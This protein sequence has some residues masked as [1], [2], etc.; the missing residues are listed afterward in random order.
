MK[1]LKHFNEELDPQ[2]YISAGR[3]LKNYGKNTKGNKLVDYGYEKSH[4]FYNTHIQWA[5]QNP[6]YTGKITNPT[7]NFYYGLPKWNGPQSNVNSQLVNAN[8]TEDELVRDWKYGL[9]TLSFTLEF[10]FTPSE[11][12]KSL[13]PANDSSLQALKGTIDHWRGFHLFTMYVKLSY[14]EDGLSGYNYDEDEEVEIK[15]GDP[16]YCDSTDLYQHTKCLDISL[17]RLMDKNIY[18][19]FADRQSALKFKRNLP[20]LVNPH[21]EKIMDLLSIIGGGAEEVE[22]IFESFNKIRINA[23]YQDENIK[24]ANLF[25][26][27]YRSRTI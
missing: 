23:L 19:I 2:T 16:A 15:P 17:N 4:G 10:R 20:S 5:G 25:N 1:H 8:L 26:S 14:W 21:K 13:I 18:G 24:G 3:S 11:E 9:S 12:L 6:V 7:C 27:W 22:E